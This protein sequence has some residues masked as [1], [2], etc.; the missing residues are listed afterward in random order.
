MGVAM[1][2]GDE[3]EENCEDAI[4]EPEGVAR[5]LATLLLTEYRPEPPPGCMSVCDLRALAAAYCSGKLG[6]G[7]SSPM[8][9]MLIDPRT[10]SMTLGRRLRAGA[11]A[12][13]GTSMLG[14]PVESAGGDVGDDPETLDAD[15]QDLRMDLRAPDLSFEGNGAVSDGGGEED[16]DEGCGAWV[17]WTF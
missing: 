6:L 2:G 12:T 17:Y 1:G 9:P 8:L 7:G 10:I 4:D 5:P 16:A 13:S 14:R 11:A 15:R 3:R